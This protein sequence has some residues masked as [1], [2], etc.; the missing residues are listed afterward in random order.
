[1]GFLDDLIAQTGGTED[2]PLGFGPE[3][4][5]TH[6]DAVK[7]DR[8]DE[9]A[10]ENTKAD[11]PG[12]ANMVKELGK[13]HD[14]VEDLSQDVFN[15]AIKGDP[16]IRPAHDMVP[17]HAPHSPTMEGFAESKTLAEL[18]QYTKGDRYSAA[19]AT[20]AMQPAIEDAYR[21]MEEA[22]EA[23][24][25]AQQMAEALAQAA[26]DALQA[27]E[28]ADALDPNDPN[29]QAAAEAAQ[30]ALQALA[31]AQGAAAGSA[32]NAQAQAEAAAHAAGNGLEQA[33]RKAAEERAEEDDL[34]R[35]FG[36]EDG[37]LKMM[38][39]AERAALAKTLRGNRLAKFAKLIGQFR[40]FAAAEA[41]RKIKH[42]PSEISGMQQGNDLTRLVPAEL[43]NLAIPE[44]EDDFWERYATSQLWQWELTGTERMGKGPIIAVCDESGSMGSADMGGGATR[45]AWSK[46]FVLALYDQARREKR[47]FHYIG[48]SSAS[49][50]WHTQFPNGGGKA[51]LPA[52][53]TMTEHFWGGGT[54]YE[55]PLTKAVEIVEDYGTR[56][57]PKPDVVFITDDDYGSLDEGFMRRWNAAKNDLQMRCF[58]VGLHIRGRA[59]ALASV[60][61]N[62]RLL[63]SLA[64]GGP[65]AVADIFR[66]I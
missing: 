35:G 53:V 4:D 54:N 33:A 59:G 58:G 49:Q 63:A 42:A 7:H 60:S 27:A 51:S 34:F 44:T 47:D 2:D 18:R 30:A 45:E 11:S 28:A 13:E 22:R 31:G 10:W 5:P 14:Y 25:R 16:E 9:V 65:D 55:R 40:T 38:D 3:P 46:A 48:F 15:L 41:R 39:F 8:F 32:A 17:T 50:V 62:V 12:L 26:A 6:T 61:D 1:M 36:V 20:V 29:A 23:A 56:D 24:A 21:R 66:T 37:E 19:M 43:L 57:L 52:V 64:N